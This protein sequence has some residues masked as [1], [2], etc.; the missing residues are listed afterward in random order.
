MNWLLPFVL[1]ALSLLLADYLVPGIHFSGIGAALVAA[2]VLGV[3]NTL[4][5]PLL[6]I[7]T[8]PLSVLTLGIFVLVINGVCFALTAALVPGFQVYSF[9]GA[10]WGALTTGILNWLIQTL[11]WKRGE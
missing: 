3:V 7:L 4:L 8:L 1:S 2:V 9:G 10:F 5:R 11:F 6:I